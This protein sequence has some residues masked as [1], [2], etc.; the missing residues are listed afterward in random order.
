MARHHLIISGT[1]RSGT[2][3]LVQLLSE[4]KFDT[5]FKD[6]NQ[7]V[8]PNSRAG[9]EKD[10]RDPNAPYIVKGPAIC[11]Y[12]DDYLSSKEDVIID[13]ALVPVRDLF[14]AAESRRF[15]AEEQPTSEP[16]QLWGGLWHTKE[17][18]DQEL[19]LT[20]KFYNLLYALSKHD[21]PV[22]LLFFPRFIVDPDYLFEKLSPILWKPGSSNYPLN[23]LERSNQDEILYPTFLT[24]F[25][26]TSK[27]ALVH[28]FLDQHKTQIGQVEERHADLVSQLSQAVERDTLVRT[29]MN[30]LEER[31]ALVRSLMNQLEERDALVRS[32]ASH[33]AQRE[34]L[35]QSLSAQTAEQEVLLQSLSAQ[36]DQTKLELE[37]TKAEVMDYALSWSWRMT[38][39][40]RKI[41][42]SIKGEKNV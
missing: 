35:V 27:P 34:S 16:D 25:K 19:V 23:G 26:K 8:D 41:Y 2:T 28:S 21:I 10:L 14:S 1:G 30:Q 24:A 39:P 20:V 32:L 12:L 22:T 38:R 18:A 29:L 42:Q 6:I 13:H 5:G 36:A 31:D 7:F 17:P 9:L 40:L 15:V 37:Q 4:L 33:L 11:D 3:F